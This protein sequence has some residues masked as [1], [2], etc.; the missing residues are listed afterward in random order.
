M[1][2][3][4]EIYLIVIGIIILFTLEQCLYFYSIERLLLLLLKL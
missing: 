1:I 3:G 2:I 4:L